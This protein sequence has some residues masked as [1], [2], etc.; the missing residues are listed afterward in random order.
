M[1]AALAFVGSTVMIG[2]S[3][4]AA[5][6]AIAVPGSTGVVTLCSSSGFSCAYGG[7]NG[8]AAQEADSRGWNSGRYWSSGNP[9]SG[10]SP[11]QRHNCTTYIQF[12]LM[13][14]KFPFPGWTDDA[15][16]WDTAATNAGS[17]VNHT[18]AVGSVAQ[19]NGSGHVAWVEQV[20]STYIVTTSD[21]LHGGT[22][23]LEIKRSSPAWPDNFIH[24]A[25][26]EAPLQ[27]D[28]RHASGYNWRDQAGTLHTGVHLA[29]WAF[30]LA[31]FSK[32]VTVRIG[33]GSAWQAG[34]SNSTT[35]VASS[36]STSA[37]K[38][39][40]VYRIGTTHG[41]SVDFDVPLRGPQT[42]YISMVSL[43]GGSTLSLGSMKVTI[44]TFTVQGAPVDPTDD[45]P[46]PD[47]SGPDTTPVDTPDD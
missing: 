3:T 1:L 46:D 11:L 26:D 28:V 10:T 14:A 24:L 22:N 45:A 8:T 27:G 42:V 9:V 32:H 23:R 44:P 13:K 18:A 7:Y 20:T 6:A 17:K 35:V 19:W 15:S 4:E 36:T 39:S 16:G 29:G 30:D 40:G 31:S 41:F 2:V 43:S 12:R 25:K 47:D 33:V 37:P 34:A 5:H 38:D 21:N